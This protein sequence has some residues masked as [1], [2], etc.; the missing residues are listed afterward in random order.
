MIMAGRR[1]SSVELTLGR[2][3]AVIVAILLLLWLG[4]RTWHPG[5][6]TY[7]QQGVDVSEAQGEIDWS[8]VRSDGSDFAYIT[9]TSGDADRD[10]QFAENWRTSAAAGIKRGAVHH[11]RLCKLAA[12]QAT[13]FISTVPREAYELPA[14]VDLD[15]D[16]TCPNPPSRTVVVQEL[17]IFIKAVEA[18]TEKP[19]I[20]R[21][22]RAFENEFAVSRAINRPLWLSS[23][24]FAPSY[25]ERPW[26]M[27]RANGSRTVDGIAGS[28]GWSVVRN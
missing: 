10:A 15:N 27:W 25:G 26:V 8:K 5:R 21:V 28:V 1:V 2:A 17:A 20:L 23:F 9:A 4:L 6:S 3:L 18:H 11:Y 14:V 24:L 7:P 13:N 12:E 16:P 19:M 22:S